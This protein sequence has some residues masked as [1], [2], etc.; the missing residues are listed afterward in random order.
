MNM[1][2]SDYYGAIPN[3]TATYFKLAKKFID[4]KDAKQGKALSYYLA[5]RG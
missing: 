1:V 3:D 2:Y 4:D 5:M